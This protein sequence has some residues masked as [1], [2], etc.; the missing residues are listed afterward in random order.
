MLKPNPVAPDRARIETLEFRAHGWVPNSRL[1]VMLIRGAL[2]RPADDKE[3]HA[4]YRANGWGGTWTWSVYDFHHYHSTAHE[5]LA[6][7]SGEA[8]LMLGGPKGQ[9]V[10][11]R[12]G[13]L[14]VLPAGTGHKR[15][16]ASPDFAVCGAYPPGQKADLLREGDADRAESD[17]AES[18]RA[19]AEGRIAAV[20]LP[21]T[22]PF[23]GA[24]GPLLRL[25]QAL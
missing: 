5:A 22:D 13:D 17:R 15:L 20:P 4:L 18:D 21:P 11:V 10:T 16:A 7:A 6:V 9:E 12:A 24:E 2:G 1:P 23:Y 19:E 14:A 25:W 3:V 8:R